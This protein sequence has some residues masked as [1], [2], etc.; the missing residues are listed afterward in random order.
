MKK[1]FAI[2]I[3]VLGCNLAVAAYGKPYFDPTKISPT[4]IAQPFAEGSRDMQQEIEKIIEL[5][6]RADEKEVKKAIREAKFKAEILVL[7]TDKNLTKKTH[8]K[9]YAFINRSLETAAM[10]SDQAKEYWKMRR[11]Y[12]VDNRIKA[13]VDPSSSYAYPSGH[14]IAAYVT[15]DILDLMMPSTDKSFYRQAEEIAQHRVLAGMHFQRD[16]NGGRQLEKV[17]MKA[18][19]ENPD[20]SVDF[21]T[22][23][24]EFES[25]QK[26]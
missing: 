18:L 5:Q 10:V 17:I 7:A 25:K 2:I 11:P 24:A 13:L 8:P 22:A 1:Y 4:V 12:L 26:K 6:Q 16:L 23:K 21:A 9:L 3:A 19:K 15:A 14:T 20:F